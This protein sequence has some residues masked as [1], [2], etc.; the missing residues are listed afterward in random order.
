[1]L[2]LGTA[3]WNLASFRGG[4]AKCTGDGGPVKCRGGPVFLKV[5]GGWP[6]WLYA[7]LCRLYGGGTHDYSVSPSPLWTN[8][9]F[10]LGWTGLGVGPRGIRD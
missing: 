6:S 7:W 5:I 2:G 4:P 3:V 9:V 1:M 8:W 10:D